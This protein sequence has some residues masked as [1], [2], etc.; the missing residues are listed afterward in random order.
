M[1]RQNMMASLRARGLGRE[2]SAAACGHAAIEAAEGDVLA[3]H[4]RLRAIKQKICPARLRV[5][6]ARPLRLPLSWLPG[7]SPVHEVKCFSLGHLVRSVPTSPT[8]CRTP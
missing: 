7:A 3:A 5:R 1:T 6:L 2:Q 8:S 4:E